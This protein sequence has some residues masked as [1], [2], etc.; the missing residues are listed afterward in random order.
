MNYLGRKLKKKLFGKLNLKSLH[1]N[2]LRDF[3]RKKE[4]HVNFCDKHVC[5]S[6]LIENSNLKQNVGLPNTGYIVFIYF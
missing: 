1:S 6:F 4:F 5:K 3:V 2:K